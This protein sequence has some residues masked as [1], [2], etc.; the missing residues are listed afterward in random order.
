V[1][2]GGTPFHWALLRYS[3]DPTGPREAHEWLSTFDRFWLPRLAAL[4]TELARGRRAR[5]GSD[6]TDPTKET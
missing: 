6:R 3:V 2:P 4:D 5:R 1:T